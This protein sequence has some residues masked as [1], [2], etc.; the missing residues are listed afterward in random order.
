M[1]S[2]SVILSGKLGGI[3]GQVKAEMPQEIIADDALKHE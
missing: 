2:V 1:E 3:P